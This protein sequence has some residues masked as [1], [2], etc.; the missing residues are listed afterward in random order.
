MGKHKP[1]YDPGGRESITIHVVFCSNVHPVVDC[2][3]YVIVTNSKKVKVSGRKDEQL[4][5]RKHTMYAGGLKETPYKDMMERKPDHV[6]VIYFVYFYVPTIPSKTDHSSSCFWYVA[7][8][9]AA[10]QASGETENISRHTHGQ[11]R[12]QCV[13]K[14]GRRHASTG[15]R[16]T[17]N[18]DVRNTKREL[19]REVS[20]SRN[21]GQ[22]VI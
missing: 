18:H 22:F 1:I 2:G 7:Q 11:S 9:S 17:Q 12:S 8:E 3:D 4:L 13:E 15:L 19:E 10:R 16:P 21:G 14:L 5:F 20:G 6:R